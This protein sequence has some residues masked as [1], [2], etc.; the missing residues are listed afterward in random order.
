MD[1]RLDRFF[2]AWVAGRLVEERDSSQQQLAVELEDF[3]EL[4]G[5]VLRDDVLDADFGGFYS[6]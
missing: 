6:V 2:Q 1:D 3:E 4:G 5:D